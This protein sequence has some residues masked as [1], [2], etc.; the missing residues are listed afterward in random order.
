M[1][2]AVV[3]CTRSSSVC[4]V[5]ELHCRL[6]SSDVWVGGGDTCRVSTRGTERGDDMG[7]GAV[8]V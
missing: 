2:A 6:V 5:N 8:C 1:G 3:V 4:E 7:E